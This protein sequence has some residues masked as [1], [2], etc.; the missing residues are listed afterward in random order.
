MHINGRGID[1]IKYCNYEDI[2]KNHK[3]FS[4]IKDRINKIYV[5]DKTHNIIIS[6]QIN[7][8]SMTYNNIHQI[9]LDIILIYQRY[10]LF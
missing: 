6:L 2:I 10:F 8:I 5:N 9:D 3:L 1:D 7:K 4:N